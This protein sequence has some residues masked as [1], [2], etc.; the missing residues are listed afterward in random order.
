MNLRSVMAMISQHV[1][2][3]LKTYG[4][5]WPPKKPYEGLEVQ[6]LIIVSLGR[7]N[8]HD[9]GFPFIQVYASDKE[10]NLYDLGIHDHI[11]LRGQA[12]V[13]MDS[14]G[15]NVFRIWINKP[16]RIDSVWIASSLLVDEEAQIR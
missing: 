13:N 8:L 3:V 9:S 4:Y 6:M 14:L 16:M 2:Q 7:K 15:A 5:N 11:C 12:D 1:V 10:K